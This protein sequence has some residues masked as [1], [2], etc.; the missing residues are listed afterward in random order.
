MKKN[1]SA[2]LKAIYKNINDGKRYGYDMTNVTYPV[3]SSVL[4]IRES[5]G[6]KYIM[7]R[8]AGESANKNTLTDLNWIITVIFKMSPS[9]FL[10]RYITDDESKIIYE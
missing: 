1:E 4:F 5:Y 6:K 10:Q 2:A 8:H 9:E 3:F 7:W